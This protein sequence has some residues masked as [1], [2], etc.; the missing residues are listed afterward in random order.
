VI[1]SALTPNRSKVQPR[2]VLDSSA[3]DRS[4]IQVFVTG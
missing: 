3:G 2:V 1:C 4:G